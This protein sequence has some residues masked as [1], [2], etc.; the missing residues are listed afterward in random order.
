MDGC[1]SSRELPEKRDSEFSVSTHAAAG[2]SGTAGPGA[3]HP[4]AAIFDHVFRQPGDTRLYPLFPE[5][6]QNSQSA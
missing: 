3:N 5:L 6:A 1:L 4:P 2:F